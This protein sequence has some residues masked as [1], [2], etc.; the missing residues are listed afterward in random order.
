[1]SEPRRQPPRGALSRASLMVAAALLGVAVSTAPKAKAATFNWGQTA[2]STYSWNDGA[3]WGG[4]SVY[5]NA[6]DD[7]ANLNS[8]LAGAETVN[9]NVPITIGSLN[10]G[11]TTAFGYTLAAGTAG[12]LTLDGASSTAIT[13]T[14]TA[15]DTISAS[16][17]FND[18]LTITSNVA[19][20]A[21]TLSGTNIRSVSSDIT[22]AGTGSLATGS[23][24]VSGIISTAGNLIKNGTGITALSGANTYAGTTSV[25]A[26]TLYINGT[27]ALPV[28]SAVSIANGGVLDVVQT[29]TIGSLTGGTTSRLIN[30]S[31]TSKVVTIGRDDT[32]T[33][34]SGLVNPATAARVGIAKIGAGTLTFAPVSAS[35]FTGASSISGG[36]WKLDF[37]AGSLSSMLASALTLTVSGGNLEVKGKGSLPVSQTLGAVTL[38]STGGSIIMDPNSSTA[39]TDLTL[40]ALTLPTTSNGGFILFNAPTNTSVKIGTGITNALP[41]A[42]LVFSADAGGLNS[43]LNV[44]W[45]TNAGLTATA[46]GNTATYTADLGGT[47]ISAATDTNNSLIDNTTASQTTTVGVATWTTNSLK[48]NAA[49]GATGQTL[50]LGANNLTLT[51]GGLLF[52]GVNDYTISSTTGVLN[53]GLI[54]VAGSSELIVYNYGAKNLTISAIIGTGA[55]IQTLTKAGTGTLTLTGANTFTGGVNVDGGVLS[56]SNVTAAGAGSLGNGSATVVTIRDGATLRYTGSGATDTIA[57]T[58]A[59]GHTY[60]LQGGYATIDVPITAATLILSGAIGGSGG[61]IKAG[62]GTLRPS[63]AS[64]YTG[65][66]FVTAGTLQAGVATAAFG[67]S[68]SPLDI[69][70]GAFADFNAND[71]SIGSLSGAGTIT[72]SSSATAKTITVGGANIST[73]FSGSFTG[74]AAN[75]LTKTG[76][77]ILTLAGSTTSTWTGNHQVN[78]GILRLASS[79]VLAATVPMYVANAAGPAM[80]ELSSGVSQSVSRLDFGGS[81]GAASSQGTVLIGSGATLTLAGNLTYTSTNNPLAAYINGAGALS[82]TA[83]RTITVGESTSVDASAAELSISAPISSTGAFGIVKTGFGNLLLSGANTFSGATTTLTAGGLILDYTAQNNAKIPSANSLT[84][85]GGGSLVLRGNASA[86]T[87]QDV[88]STTLA[89][90]GFNA[91][92]LTPGGSQKI[93]FNMGAFTRAASAGTVRFTLPTGTQDATNGIITPTPNVNGVLGVGAAWATVTD[94]AG[95]TNFAVNNGTNNIGLLTS[96]EKNDVTTWAAG[97]HVTDTAGYTGTT[98][99]AANINTLRFNSGNASTVTIGAN[100]PLSVLTGGILQTANAANASISGGRLTSGASN[101]L[102]FTTDVATLPLSVSSTISGNETITKTGLG[103]LKLTGVNAYTG[104]TLI[105]GGT[106]QVSGGKAIGDS[107]VVTLTNVRASVFELLGNETVGGIAGGNTGAGGLGEVRIGANTLTLSQSTNLTY[108]GLLTGSGT[109]IKS[110]AGTMTI[111]ATAGASF[112][113]TFEISQGQVTLSGNVT[114]LAAV[115]SVVLSGPTAV[116]Y[117][118]ND[119]ST[120]VGSRINDT[121]TVTLRNTAGN[122]GLSVR[123]TTG[124]ST[125]TETVGQ[126]ILDAGHNTITADATTGST[127][128]GGWSFTNATSLVRNNFATALLVGKNLGFGST[129]RGRIAFSV[130]PGG[131]IGGAG[132]AASTTISIFPYFVGESTTGTPTTS[133]VGNS[134]LTF[135]STTEGMR[136][137]DTSTEYVV[138]SASPAT[139]TNNVRYTATKAITTPA[140]INSLVLDSATGVAL[141]G[142]ASSMEI[143]SGAILAAGAGSSSIGTITALTSGATP[144]PYHVYVTNASGVLTLD[145]PLTSVTPLV[146]SGAGS[147]VL[148]SASNA[149]TDIYFNQ[150]AVQADALSKL[151]SGALKFFGGTLKFGAA[152]DASSGPKTILIGTGGATFDT[153]G[154]SP[155]FANG[156][157]NSG[158]GGLTKIGTGTLTLNGAASYTGATTVSAGTLAMGVNSAIG[159]GAL[160]VSSAATLA[161]GAYNATVS[162]LTLSA[163]SANVISGTGTLTVTGDATLNQGTFSPVLAGV[164]NLLKSTAGQTVSLGND[165]NTFTGYTWIQ[166]GTLSVTKLAP[167]GTNSSLGAATGVNARILIGNGTG[168]SALLLYASTADSSTDRAILLAGT[169][170][171]ATID[172]GNSTGLLTMSGEAY[173]IFAGAKALTLQGAN[174]DVSTPNT[175]SG[176]ITDGVGVVG[177][178]KAGAGTWKLSGANTFTG[179][180]TVSGGTL[181]LGGATA[182]GSGAATVTGGTLNLNGQAITNAVTVSGGTLSGGTIALSQVIASSGTITAIL[183]GATALTKS[184]TGTLTLSGANTYSLG[185][186]I[187]G[188]TLQVGAGGETGSLGS[189][190]VTL[191]GGTLTINRSNDFDLSNGITGTGSFTQSGFGRTTLSGTN[192]FNG[193]VTVANGTLVVTSNAALGDLSNIVTIAGNANTVGTAG[194]TL[195]LAP[196]AQSSLS[197]G[198]TINISGRAYSLRSG[199]IVG[200][201]ESITLSGSVSTLTSTNDSALVQ[202]GGIMTLSGT[203]V[204]GPSTSYLLYTGSSNMRGAGSYALTGT[205]T[206]AGVIYRANGQGT[207]IFNPTDASGFSGVIRSNTGTYRFL[208]PT[209]LGTNVATGTSAALYMSATSTM[210]FR[211]G[212]TTGETVSW[213]KSLYL[214]NSTTGTLVADHAPGS[215]AINQ[216]NAFASAYSA[217]TSAQL[218]TLTGRNGAGFTFT[219]FT[220]SQQASNG[221]DITVTNTLGTGTSTIAGDVLGWDN[222]NTIARQFNAIVSGGDL[223]LTGSIAAAQGTGS[224]NHLMVKSGLGTLTIQG[225]AS[226]ITGDVTLSSGGD[227]SATSGTS[228][229]TYITD[230]RSLGTTSTGV[231]KLGNATTITGSLT[232]GVAGTTPTVGGLTTSRVISINTTTKPVTINASQPGSNP[233]VI[234]SNFTGVT[235]GTSVRGL[236]LGGTNTADNL[237]SGILA[238]F[239]TAISLTKND[240][241]T[242]ALSGSNTYTGATTITGGTLKLK[243]TAAASNIIAS[244]AAVTFDNN[245]LNFTAGGTLEL[246][247]VLNTATT[248]SLGAL[249]PTAGMGTVKLTSN[250]FG[251]TANLIFASLAS[252]NKAA[253]INIDTSSTPAG[254]VTFTAATASSATALFGDGHVYVNGTNFAYASGV[255]NVVIGIPNYGTTPGFVNAAAGTATLTATNHN[256][257]TGAISAQTSLT[258]SSLKLTTS[259]LTMASGQT[260]TVQLGAN[261]EAPILQSGGTATISGGTGITSNGSGALVFR[262]NGATDVLNLD[263]PMLVSTTGGFTKTGLG[264][265]VLNA[266]NA[267]TTGGAISIL[268][269]T[270]KMGSLSG[271]AAVIG[272]S[273]GLNLIVRTGATLDLNGTSQTVGYVDGSGTVTNTSATA[274]TLTTNSSGTLWSGSFTE[275][276]GAGKLNVTRTA[277]GSSTWNGLSTNTGVMTFG[278]TS[279]KFV[280]VT[281]L[282][283]IGTASGIGKGDSAANAASLVFSGDNTS[284]LAYAGQASVSTD[285][286]FTLNSAIATPGAALANNSNYNAAL[287]FSNTGAIAFGTAANGY[288][289]AQTLTLTGSPG[290]GT[291]AD[292]YF[293]PKLT[294]NTANTSGTTAAQYTALTKAGTSI[295]VLGNTANDYSGTTT[296]SAGVL[297]TYVS[298]GSTLSTNSPLYINGGQLQTQGEFV[299]NLASSAVAGSPTV[300]LGVTA[301]GFSA[302]YEKLTVAI[303]GTLAPTA[304]TWG[305]N[306][307]FAAGSTVGIVLNSATSLAEVEFRNAIDLN[308]GSTNNVTRTITVTDNAATGT[309]YATISGAISNSSGAP[310]NGVALSISGG[311]LRLFGDNTYAGATKVIAGTLTVKSLGSSSTAGVATSVGISTGANTSSGAVRLGNAGTTNGILQY[312]GSGETSDRLIQLDQTTGTT[313]GTEIHSDGSGPLV[314]TNVL[315]NIAAGAKVLYL[316]GTNTGENKVTSVLADNTDKLGV[317][318]D[319]GGTWILSGA[320]TFTGTVNINANA[321]VGNDAAFGTA[322]TLKMGGNGTI[323]AYGDDRTVATPIASGVGGT[324]AGM[325]FAGNYSLNFTGAWTFENTQ[326]SNTLTNNIVSGKTLTFSGATGTWNLLNSN[327]TL[328]FNGSG[329][330]VWSVPTSTSTNF[331]SNITYSG[332]GTLTI[333]ATQDAFKAVATAPLLTVS[334]GTV[335]IGSNN[336]LPTGAT[337]GNT[338]MSPAVSI[339]ATLDLNGYAQDFN[340]FTA[341]SAGN[342]I[343]D[344]KSS[345]ARTVTFGYNDATVS[346]GN[347]AAR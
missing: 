302:G 41:N 277:S 246:V 347:P 94:S 299:R 202:I 9:L 170:G 338:V 65:P 30:S 198:R 15:A 1:M 110:G 163:G 120:A 147:L 212:T 259:N 28:R 250:G 26:G 192:T 121:A 57:A 213:G 139:G 236:I 283:N 276:P 305:T 184:S 162:A 161:M 154:F 346:V 294:N 13:K 252:P 50:S 124:T 293:G 34:F 11:A 146:K 195:V 189:G 165:A 123:R 243:A 326:A 8:A 216:I 336:V 135:V 103:T 185:T 77:G 10:I 180:T 232:I 70:A 286:L 98:P 74:A 58:G 29:L 107:S 273:G 274:T 309:D 167:A 275:G 133:N 265:L 222:T 323:F 12:Y 126:L 76:S 237:L 228:G 311:I 238:D 288:A 54:P 69:S 62:A 44:G 256:L 233:V 78:G 241:G 143:T 151:G 159:T 224:I 254:S 22:F 114:Q 247:A 312:V 137:L 239:G 131:A 101:E 307:F 342:T 173:G 46:L 329:D 27:T 290:S 166:D 24:V 104:G 248:E 66:T 81:S 18:S 235:T 113:G 340:G 2:L 217:G 258:I 240:A 68:S 43:V 200:I 72:N 92:T 175:Y 19:T 63:A 287:V 197:T 280:T 95:V 281:T 56:F 267:Q 122:M 174:G 89:S 320:N 269:G 343:L 36:S 136:P 313:S 158:A 318:I 209:K 263:T 178:T 234:S 295:W 153:N 292:N 330:T 79:N 31:G 6:I 150:G 251:G 99:G 194:G 314:L 285:R 105:Q 132:A 219:G 53:S 221:T 255:S 108:S 187:S 220:T 261:G 87:S 128:I 325:A 164:M 177:V 37:S 291:S 156:I 332:T 80:L 190:A 125:G 3:N 129:A 83:T 205:I 149:F 282:A 39:G 310:A 112:T 215:S 23:I 144:A 268:E 20:V 71:Q 303:G 244:A 300:T 172:S 86:S 118:P 168:T 183:T 242:W 127:P 134:F 279:A 64:T 301:S 191:S 186:T 297:N 218:L 317:N 61:L 225:V 171:G 96:A 328:T 331:G 226:T 284:G 160:T 324:S 264:T 204:T 229:T 176:N 45:A 196:G 40:G 38:G 33:T 60:T 75:L 199:S 227:A 142:T 253:A 47:T 334:S 344:A 51:N 304:L 109:L 130:N 337:Y 59:G 97:D 335:R 17:Q 117:L 115:T 116:L 260:L 182:L 14:G 138:D 169:T 345:S 245:A 5:P 84:L 52:T 102:I 25:N 179:T 67:S 111:D 278:L 55:G 257:V 16:I 327:R 230:F 210:E 193:A 262:V 270:V 91:I 188:G 73:T 119:Q 157:G 4:G 321:G 308:Q 271:T 249:T 35:T 339:T 140:A 211:S 341:T 48:I 201:G 319:G 231:I 272:A 315:N 266:V 93:V 88:L 148:T 208:D 181:L 296:I 100:L 7:V 141:T 85:N 206:G 49:A 306:G 145:S 333:G 42:R 32:S 106:L 289:T 223:I 203:L 214:G 155:S 298:A 82:L 207:L 90:G 322:G 152:F 21:L 316:R